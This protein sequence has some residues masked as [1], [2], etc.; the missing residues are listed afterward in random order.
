V[1]FV[2]LASA[3][4]GALP[5]TLS[6]C[7]W[8]AQYED[9]SSAFG[10]AGSALDAQSVLEAGQVLDGGVAQPFCPPDAGPL[11]YCMD[12]DGVDTSALEPQVNEAEVTIVNGTYVS[13]PSSL[14]VALQGAGSFG[15]YSKSFSFQPTTSRLEFQIRTAD[16]QEG[17]TTLAI[18][19]T[20]A[21][22]ET[23]RTLNVVVIPN[24]GF[25][26]FQVQ[27]YFSLADGGTEISA[28]TTFQ[29]DAGALSDASDGWHHVV[30]TLTVNDAAAQY[31]SGLTVDNQVLED[32]GQPLVLPW[33]EGTASLQ[34]GVTY[35]AAEGPQFYFDNVRADFGL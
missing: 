25:D 30:L 12:F 28:H 18:T 35:A 4:L 16:L 31:F 23:N 2:S 13:P 14:F 20:Q 17:V 15:R 29:V 8:L 3:S 21:S 32:G 5:V 9:L 10:D 33:A 26:G 6:G 1:K 19:L 11:V 34:I 24:N 22:T 27:E 7:Y